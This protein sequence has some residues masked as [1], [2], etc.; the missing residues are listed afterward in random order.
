MPSISNTTITLFNNYVLLESYSTNIVS[1]NGLLAG[2]II[3]KWNDTAGKANIN[4]YVLFR[5]EDAISLRNGNNQFY[6]VDERKYYL[7]F[8]LS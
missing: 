8:T 4:D 3:K 7:S 6:L 5:A 2:K 1:A